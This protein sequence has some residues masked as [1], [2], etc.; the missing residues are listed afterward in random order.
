MAVICSSIWSKYK[1]KM[2]WTKAF[3]SSYAKNSENP[4]KRL[5]PFVPYISLGCFVSLWKL[6]LPEGGT[7]HLE[8]LE[9]INTESIKGN[10]IYY[11][12]LL[13][14][15]FAGIP[16]YGIYKGEWIAYIATLPF[17]VIGSIRQIRIAY[18]MLIYTLL[19]YMLFILW[20]H[21]QGLRFLFPVLPFYI[22]FFYIWGLCICTW[23]S[24]MGSNANYAC[25]C[26]SNFICAI[27]FWSEVYSSGGN[28]TTN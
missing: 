10:S 19:T 4:Y 26:T 24:S 2:G 22:L 25:M 11:K 5:L 9:R 7:S 21:K 23:P 6:V 18:H 20:P 14:N 8:H 12:D 3:V 13:A 17:V 15:F 28:P 1:Q 16:S 27:S